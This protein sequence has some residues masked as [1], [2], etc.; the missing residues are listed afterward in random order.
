M[1]AYR[2]LKERITSDQ[3]GG[4]PEGN[5]ILSRFEKEVVAAVVLAA[6][7]DGERPTTLQ[8]CLNQVEMKGFDL[9]GEHLTSC[10]AVEIRN[11]PTNGRF[12]VS[13]EF[14]YET[15]SSG[16]TASL[17]VSDL[18]EKTNAR[19][20]VKAFKVLSPIM[21]HE[22][23]FGS[24]DQERHAE[25]LA[26]ALF[27]LYRVTLPVAARFLWEVFKGARSNS[28]Q[29]VAGQK[30]TILSIPRFEKLFDKVMPT[31]PSS[32]I[33]KLEA[34]WR[35]ESYL[36]KRD[37]RL[38]LLEQQDLE[39][40]L[41]VYEEDFEIQDE[42]FRK[43]Y[44]DYAR[45]KSERTPASEYLFG[46]YDWA[47]VSPILNRKKKKA[48]Q[49]LG[50]ATR[51]VFV[52]DGQTLDSSD[53]D[54][55]NRLD[56]RRKS[57]EQDEMRDF[58]EQHRPVLE[59][60]PAVL[61]RW[62]KE[63]Y[64]K[65]INCDDLWQGIIECLEQ[66]PGSTDNSLKQLSILLIGHRQEKPNQFKGMN[67]NAC[68]FFEHQYKYMETFLPGM[69]FFKNT[70]AIDFTE[71]VSP[72]IE[73]PKKISSAKKAN[74][75]EF[76]V[77]IQSHEGESYQTVSE[78][79]L[80][81]QFPSSSVYSEYLGDLDRLTRNDSGSALIE[82]S[83]DRDAAGTKGIPAPISLSSTAGFQTGAGGK[84]SFVPPL[85]K[86]KKYSLHTKWKN[87]LDEALKRDLDATWAVETRQMFEQFNIE[88][89]SAI[90][91][92]VKS[93]LN[94]SLTESEGIAELYGNIIERIALLPNEST[95]RRLLK[96][97]LQVGTV[98]IPPSLG[99][100]SATIVCPWHPL[101]LQA[102]CAKRE[103]LKEIIVDLLSSVKGEFSDEIGSLF[104]NDIAQLFTYPPRPEICI[105]WEGAK[106]QKPEEHIVTQSMGAYSLHEV[107]FSAS[108]KKSTL[109]DDS[110][111]TARVVRELIEEYLRLQP[112]EQDNLS[113]ALY[114]S[115]S[116][117]LPLAVVEEINRLN[118]ARKEV[119]R[120]NG[121]SDEITCQVVMTHQDP[122]RLRDAYKSLLSRASDPDE[123]LGTEVTGEFLSRVRINILAAANITSLGR[124]KPIDIVLCQDVVSRLAKRDWH[125]ISRSVLPA[126]DIMPHR[127]GRREPV[128]TASDVSRLYLV[129]PAQ[130]SAGWQHLL[131]VAALFKNEAADTWK[132]GQCHILARKIDFAEDNLANI[133][134]DTHRIGNWVVNYDELLD[135][136][137]LEEQGVRV[138][139]YEQG[140]THGRNLVISSTESNAF[141]EA[142]LS[143]EVANILGVA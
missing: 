123:I 139:R 109:H 49:K 48:S 6:E 86:G 89:T 5:L 50:Q 38:Q 122:T 114:N 88:Y 35:T 129:C 20:W 37:E 29:N 1:A 85:A 81:W 136:R 56:I 125:R 142:S 3:S 64:D 82:C 92:L 101:R 133:F 44:L 99:E 143:E 15:Q 2:L 117:S 97:I 100:G 120:E 137:L 71:K 102:I 87:E 69:V 60:E 16:S 121:D 31:Q 141:L 59:Q 58:F 103:Q 42:D 66:S 70:L 124:S 128:A 91:S 132:T 36:R 126:R 61:K 72:L 135:R 112:H 23:A 62:E 65:E 108:T 54:M 33:K 140:S 83:I 134:S 105:S 30:L 12:F 76:T 40:A 118:Q 74:T 130:P 41:K 4:N 95:R 138:I 68:R 52:A 10:N 75:F 46:E 8:F 127:W 80:L 110:K 21:L 27:S 53:D 19:I 17:N 93:E 51:Q 45:S 94:I 104:F 7:A 79:K 13:A 78:H 84:G 73:K 26:Q 28:L 67:Q 34:H 43:A 116:N 55:L 25:A 14:E 57:V 11:Q 39:E 32:W 115:D 77:R 96:P 47:T 22:K 90:K 106:E 113:V 119:V 63:I 111:K 131:A 18:E 24:P 107:P 9:A 98:Q